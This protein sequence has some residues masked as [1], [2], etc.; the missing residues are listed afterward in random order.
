MLVI[1]VRGSRKCNQK[2]Q[3]TESAI[4]NGKSKNTED[5]QQQEQINDKQHKNTTEKTTYMSK[6]K[7][8]QATVVNPGA[9]NG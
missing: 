2:L 1:N 9:R 4:K 8:P 3:E 7:S 6:T 5:T